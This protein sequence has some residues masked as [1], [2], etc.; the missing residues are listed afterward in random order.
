MPAPVYL[1]DEVSG[2]GFRLAGALVRT[3]RPGEEAATLAWARASA[4]LV[5]VSATVAAGA[6]DALMRTA[7][8]ALSPLLLV[9][10]DLHGEV[11]LPDLAA[12]LRG[13]LGLEA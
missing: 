4:P 3:P 9:L 5:L 7:L 1:G 10:P 6:G 8:S 12:R 11:P 13:Q 2:A